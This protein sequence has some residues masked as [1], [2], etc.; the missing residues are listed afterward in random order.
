VVR[1]DE[2]SCGQH[3]FP[4]R[5][6]VPRFVTGDDYA[7][8]FSFEWT[9][10][11]RTQFD[12]QQRRESEETFA[13][14]TGFTPEMLRG[15]RVLDVGVG[16]G[17]FSDV[18]ARWGADV[19]GVDISFAVESARANL[20][21]YPTAQVIQADIFQLPFADASFDYIFSIG[22]LHHTP[23]CRA[24]F[25]ALPRLLKPRGEIA[26]WL[27]NAYA[28]NLRVNTFYRDLAQR[29][30]NRALYALCH[31][32]V[33]GYYLF[34]VPVLRSVLHHLVPTPSEH[35]DWR[36]RVLDTYDWYSPKYQSRHTYPEV[37]G[38]FRD[39]QLCDVVPLPEP[40]SMK[41]RR[42]A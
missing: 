37:Y 7:K 16:A 3:R 1:G 34:R 14:K 39:A 2:L 30:P 20:E 28:D 18:A 42:A 41:G 23:D 27:Y 32:A 17:R 13:L 25:A 19:V 9:V 6:G 10:H 12:D 29:L 26:I 31:L 5:D 38:W 36:W 35:P 21:R 22:V 40:V 4:V 15:K 11:A 33:P 24:A 8:N